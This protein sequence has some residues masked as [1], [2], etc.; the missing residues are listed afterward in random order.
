MAKQP[1]RPTH[2]DEVDLFEVVKF[3]VDIRRYW[4]IGG[5]GLGALAIVYALF[6]H[7]IT[8]RQLTLNDVGLNQERLV[9]LQ[10][11]IPASVTPLK[12]SFI[13]HDQGELW[14]ALLEDDFI[15]K[16]IV[17]VS[18]VNLK[19]KNEELEN[20]KRI[21]AV[22]VTLKG[23][24]AD[25]LRR[26]IQTIQD[27][28]RGLSQN[29]A[30]NTWLND[31][32]TSTRLNEFNKRAELNQLKLDEERLMKQTQNYEAIAKASPGVKD[33]QVILN[34]SNAE[35]K[36]ADK[37]EL[38][39]VSEFSGAKYL[40]LTN[41]IQAMKTEQSDLKESRIITERE[42]G[43]LEVRN[44]ALVLIEDEMGKTN[45]GGSTLDLSGVFSRLA[46]IRTPELSAEQVVMLD[47]TERELIGFDVMAR[48]YNNRLPLVIDKKGEA[49]LVMIAGILGGVLGI[50]L[51][52]YS[53]LSQAYRRRFR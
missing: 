28:I 9:L 31:E 1:L 38:A 41:R 53:K 13:E 29:L 5:F 26:D 37:N 25:R 36:L 24:D 46:S 39:S 2:D 49:K 10:T 22:R 44:Q 52:T 32:I 43:A 3:F 23:K 11:M 48:K 40:P 19:E 30:I 16:T 47:Q 15:D 34:L 8:A 21:D 20:K 6:F 50:I 12:Q 33:M 42:L 14:D 17:G 4:L 7:P 35:D 45:F 27:L 18:G 51:G